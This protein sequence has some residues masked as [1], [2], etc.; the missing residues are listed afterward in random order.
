MSWLSAINTELQQDLHDN[1]YDD[2][3]LSE[4]TKGFLTSTPP[5][6]LPPQPPPQP[7]TTTTTTTTT[8][9]T[10]TTLLQQGTSAWFKAR[11]NRLTG[12][13]IAAAVGLSPY[14]TP[15]SLWEKITGKL[16]NNIHTSSSATQHG[17]AHE[18]NVVK[19]YTHHTTRRVTETGFWVHPQHSWVGAS[20]DGLVED[21]GVLEIKCPIYKVHDHVPKYYMPQLQAEMACTNRDWTDFC[22]C[23]ISTT[24]TT[25][26]RIFRV[27]RS[28]D[29]WTWL[30]HKMKR[31]WSCVTLDISPRGMQDLSVPPSKGPP[32]VEEIKILDVQ[33]TL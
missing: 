19:M 3:L 27:Q 17:I 20:P 24:G 12:S 29:Y 15:H 11:T 30:L 6:Q 21:K 5:P 14:A 13:N 10:D 9:T 8:D 2:W 4:L 1:D 18:S 22:S 32:P 7:T 16:G 23:F 25:H 31:F 28:V 26:L 33:G